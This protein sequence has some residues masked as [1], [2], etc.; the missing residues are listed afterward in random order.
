MKILIATPIAAP[1]I[2]GPATYIKNLFQILEKEGISSVLISYNSLKSY[3]QPL[4]F[5]LYSA[6]LLSKAGGCDLIYGFN[7]ISSGLPA[8]FCSKIFRKKFIIRLG[9][10][11]L[12]ER[13]VEEGRSEATLKDYYKEPKSIRERIFI[14]LIKRVLKGA[15]RIIFT[16]DFQ[17]EIY[18]DFYDLDRSKISIIGNPFPEKINGNTQNADY[19]IL[20]AGRLIKLKNLGNLIDAFA[21]SVEKVT[22]PLTLK[23][24]GDGPET[25]FLKNKVEKLQ[26]Q[27]KIFFEKALSQNQLFEEIRKSYFCVLPSLSEITPNFALESIAMGKPIL[28]TR[29]TG[30]YE[31]F[32]DMLL[33]IDPKDVEDISRKIIYLCEE[34]N[35]NKYRKLIEGMP[36]SFSWQDITKEHIVLFKEL[37]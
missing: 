4:R 24:V 16:S 35:Y 34:E 17:K 15:D 29:E 14:W 33:F 36:L 27:D 28:L 22:M 19:Q 30:Y 37:I 32:K 7:I 2:G 12:W 23:I 8:F 5:L 20:F 13:A 11:F 26:L 25:Q 31:K 1:S 10:D 3:P 21:K 9:G 6:S 18:I